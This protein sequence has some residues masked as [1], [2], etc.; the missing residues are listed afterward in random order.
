MLLSAS[1]NLT[2]LGTS[3]TWRHIGFVLCDWICHLASTFSR[4]LPVVACVMISFLPKAEYYSIVWTD[5][6]LSVHLF[7]DTW[8]V[9]TFWLLWTWYTSICSDLC[10]RLFYRIS[11]S[12][13]SGSN[14]NLTFKVLST[15]HTAFHSG[16]TILYSTS[17]AQGS[18][19]PTSSSTASKDSLFSLGG[20][21][22][23]WWSGSSFIQSSNPLVSFTTGPEDQP[24]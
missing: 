11:R 12:R 17:S 19:A 13:I 10:F 23:V 6:T 2:S 5:R 21:V 20:G 14:G 9:C 4:H 8:V 24:V 1:K 7:I 16:C 22:P 15:Y 18:C 3:Y